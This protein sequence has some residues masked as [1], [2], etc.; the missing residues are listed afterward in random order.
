MKPSTSFSSRDLSIVETEVNKYSYNVF[1]ENIQTECVITSKIPLTDEESII[2]AITNAMT[3]YLEFIEEGYENVIYR[4]NEDTITIKIKDINPQ[5]HNKFRKYI[6][7]KYKGQ[8]FQTNY[9]N[10]L[11]WAIVLYRLSIQIPTRLYIETIYNLQNRGDNEI[12]ALILMDR[13]EYI[14]HDSFKEEFHAVCQKH[15]LDQETE[16]QLYGYL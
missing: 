1:L 13:G 9:N 6:K 5:V 15:G 12:D 10:A 16:A 11:N 14:K 8:N 2:S 7:K 4:P 3:V